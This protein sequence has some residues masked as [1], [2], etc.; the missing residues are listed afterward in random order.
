MKQIMAILLCLALCLVWTGC[1]SADNSPA[2]TTASPTAPSDPPEAAKQSMHSVSMV[3]VSLDTLADD[4]GVLFTRAYQTILVTAAQTSVAD[5][6][7]ADL[8]SKINTA[9]SNSDQLESIARSE[10]TGQADWYPYFVDIRYTPT[11]IDS[12]VFSLFGNHSSHSGGNH[13]ALATRSV[14]YDLRDGSELSLPD[15]LAPETDVAELAELVNLSLS[16]SDA[17]LWY[18][19]EDTVAELFA[20]KNGPVDNWYFSQTGLC[21]HFAPFMIGPYSSGTVIATVPYEKL[22]GVVQDRFLPSAPVNSAGSIYIKPFDS[23][24]EPA[25]V[26]LELDPDGIAAVLYCDNTVTNVRIESGAWSNDGARFIPTATVFAADTMGIHHAIALRRNPTDENASLRLVYDSGDQQ[27][28]AFIK[29]DTDGN[30][31]VLSK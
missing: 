21:F 11:R 6:I 23:A 12:T 14:T 3:S 2:D 19:Y 27:I 28:T 8:N 20:G 30:T 17:N 29:A 31:I 7:E 5:A 18:D 26:T 13:P 1:G 10:Y 24:A 4:G 25:T 9:L 22:T 15:I 16:L